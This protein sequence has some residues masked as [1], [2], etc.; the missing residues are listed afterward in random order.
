V[1]GLGAVSG[2]V[3]V[4][5]FVLSVAQG[6]LSGR[7]AIQALLLALLVN[8]LAKGVYFAGIA[9]RNRLAVL[10]RYGF[11]SACHVPLLWM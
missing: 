11:W 6:A 9:G 10:W 7:L 5:P 3:D 2:L 4:D 8:T 1:L